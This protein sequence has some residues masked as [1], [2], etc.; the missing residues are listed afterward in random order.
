[1][2]PDIY[3]YIFDS[4]FG[5]HS[6]TLPGIL[7][8]TLSDILADIHFGIWSGNLSG[9]LFRTLSDI[10]SDILSGSLFDSLFVACCVAQ[11]LGELAS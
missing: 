4:K 6:N 2:S 8:G 5:I 11:G 7:F 10:C 9:I 3:I 1:M